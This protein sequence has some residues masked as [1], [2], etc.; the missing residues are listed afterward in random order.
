MKELKILIQDI[1]Y[2]KKY[3]SFNVVIEAIRYGLILIFKR[4]IC[5][6]YKHVLDNGIHTNSGCRIQKTCL[7]CG[8]V[9]IT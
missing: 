1:Y 8:K 9:F 7:R 6:I 5:L 4:L 2:G 3:K